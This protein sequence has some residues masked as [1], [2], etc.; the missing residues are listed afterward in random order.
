MTRSVLLTLTLT[1][2]LGTTSEPARADTTSDLPALEGTWKR[3]D[4]WRYQFVTL[5]EGQR[6]VGWCLDEDEFGCRIEL[7]AMSETEL[8]G[9]AC[10]TRA[11]E[12][13]GSLS[14]MWQL[15][16]AGADRLTGRVE[17]IELDDAGKEQSR[18]WE[19]HR[20]RRV[21]PLSPEEAQAARQ[22]A[23]VQLMIDVAVCSGD[24]SSL[25]DLL[26]AP[27]VRDLGEVPGNE[28]VARRLVAIMTRLS[29]GGP[30]AKDSQPADMDGFLA[31]F[32][33]KSDGVT[34]ALDAFAAE[35]IERHGMDWYDLR[36]PSVTKH[37]KV[38]GLD[39]YTIECKAGMTIRTFVL[40][41]RGARIVEVVDGGMQ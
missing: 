39:R 1:L 11:T 13:G 24:P 20:F 17:S 28:V 32:N 14:A 10:F 33:G 36:E 31:H 18:E 38:D 30:N 35:G 5:S 22:I 7:E 4:G 21:A 3:D 9:S 19:Q 15:E 40:V 23:V 26:A 29:G 34:A 12:T 41:W 27:A 16:R 8:F 37:E 2:L 6:L 25:K